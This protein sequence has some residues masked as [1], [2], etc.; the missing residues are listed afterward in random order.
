[1][2][3][4]LLGF[5]AIGFLIRG[6]TENRSRRLHFFAEIAALILGVSL[7]IAAV[8]YSR[9]PSPDLRVVGFPFAAAMFERMSPGEWAD[10]IGFR[11]IFASI[12]NFL[13]GLLFPY[14]FLPLIL[15]PGRRKPAAT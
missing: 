15:A 14:L 2:T 8:T 7:G 12:G 6:F 4:A 11:T 3:T 10:F 13:I 9:Y 5:L 1:M